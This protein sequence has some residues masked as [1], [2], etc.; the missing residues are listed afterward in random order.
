MPEPSIEEVDPKTAWDALASKEDAILIDVRTH[1]E[2][3]FVGVPQTP[4][5]RPEPVLIEWQSYPAMAIN[6]GFVSAALASAEQAS[7]KTL[8]FLC[9]SG[10]RSLHA[11]HAVSAAARDAG[12][13]LSCVNV[14]NGFEGDPCPQGRRGGVSGWKAQG[15]PWRQS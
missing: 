1:A 4:P 5:A 13:A 15:L 2:W 10:V 12:V 8:Y 11:A 9:R 3:S 7:A 14:A 6:P